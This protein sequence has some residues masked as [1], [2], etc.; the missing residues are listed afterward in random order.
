MCEGQ[1]RRYDARWRDA[2]DDAVA[3]FLRANV[4]VLDIG[5]GRQPTIS[6][7]DRPT[8][9]HYVG[10]DI[11][12]HEL[13]F[14]G[15]DAYD[16]IVVADIATP[17]PSLSQQFDLALSW[18]VLEHVKPLDRTFANIHLYLRPGGVVVAQLSG[19]FSAFALINQLIPRR[20]GV[21]FLDRLLG[22][23]AGTVF[24][25]FYDRCYASALARIL[26]GWSEVRIVPRFR[27]AGYFAFSRTVQ[28]LYL[29]YEDWAMRSGH[30]NL[31]THYLVVARK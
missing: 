22:R 28:R 19:K 2:Y 29:R 16:E 7:A 20:V 18:Q 30:E 6:V 4:A 8:G 17:D 25:A 14:A 13:R 27:G 9:C 10:L 31:A 12:E 5:P 15:E 1:S 24:P 26:V 21:R 23:D 3:P 11:S